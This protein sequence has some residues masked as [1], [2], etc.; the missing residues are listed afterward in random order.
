LR[1]PICYF[2]ATGSV[3]RRVDSQNMAFLYSLIMHDPLTKKTIPISEFVTTSHTTISISRYLFTIRELLLNV[4]DSVECQLPPIVV[5]DFSWALIKS[6]VKAFDLCEF[7]KYLNWCY[8]ICVTNDII[9]L[10]KLNDLMPTRIILCSFHFIKSIA[11]KARKCTKSVTKRVAFKFFVS[12]LIHSTSMSEFNVFLR[13]ICVVLHE[14]HLTNSCVKSMEILRTALIHRKLTSL[15]VDD[16]DS[17]CDKEQNKV[18]GQLNKQFLQ[19]KNGIN[20]LKQE[21]PFTLY[22]NKILQSQKTKSINI[23]KKKCNLKENPFCESKLFSL[24]EDQL[25]IMPLWSSVVMSSWFNLNPKYRK[26]TG[27]TNN[28][29]EGYFGIIKNHLLQKKK[30][31]SI[32]PA[33]LAS[34]I[35]KRIVA[36]YLEFYNEDQDTQKKNTVN[37]NEPKG[38]SKKG[39]EEKW[40]KGLKRN[41]REKG[42]L[43]RS[44]RDFGGVLPGDLHER[45][46]LRKSELFK[47]T[48]NIERHLSSEETYHDEGSVDMEIN[49]SNHEE[50]DVDSGSIESSQQMISSSEESMT[51]NSN[52]SAA[53]EKKKTNS[54]IVITKSK[55]SFSLYFK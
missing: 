44:T 40:K 20:N 33:Y 51:E 17:T 35:Y 54:S 53:Q 36:K 26:I 22:F 43:F 24:I 28:P 9:Q 32:Q 11:Q 10:K 6:I 4:E 5:T 38:K 18:K 19:S 23:N 13:E 29:V 46:V 34:C 45:L 37:E 31:S 16:E 3:M 14:T 1:N 52:K 42:F 55:N 12:L 7:D 48:F 8:S 50:M 30:P 27:T 2:D 21:S 39:D 15:E 25:H 49:E 41:R 47:K